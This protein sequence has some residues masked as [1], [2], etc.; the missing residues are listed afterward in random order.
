MTTFDFNLDADFLSDHNCRTKISAYS[1]PYGGYLKLTERNVNNE[2]VTQ[3]QTA[4]LSSKE[5]KSLGLALISLSAVLED[6]E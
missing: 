5:C 6:E 3:Q 1:S 2:E 4:L